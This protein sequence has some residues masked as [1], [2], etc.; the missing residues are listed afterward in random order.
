MKL[1]S[2]V[3]ISI[4]GIA[5]SE[6]KPPSVNG[7]ASGQVALPDDPVFRTDYTPD[8]LGEELLP[9]SP[10]KGGAESGPR[11]Q[12][13][14]WDRINGQSQGV[15]RG[16]KGG[17]AAM[18]KAQE[19]MRKLIN[20]RTSAVMLPPCTS[21]F[22]QILTSSIGQELLAKLQ[23]I[24]QSRESLPVSASRLASVED[25]ANMDDR[26]QET[27]KISP[28]ELE[29]RRRL[30]ALRR[31]YKPLVEALKENS[32]RRMAM[33]TS[34]YMDLF[35]KAYI[36]EILRYYRLPPDERVL[37][38]E[39]ER[40]ENLTYEFRFWQERRE[41]APPNI[42]PPSPPDSMSDDASAHDETGPAE[43]LMAKDLAQFEGQAKGQ[44]PEVDGTVIRHHRGRHGHGQNKEE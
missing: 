43:P 19:E 5:S 35:D 4:L 20:D 29:R 3:L 7:T 6:T 25:S 22:T 42:P 40:W 15:S 13:A 31:K 12:Q 33:G 32:I 41:T 38:E 24:I 27:A 36:A 2:L 10:N 34:V 26:S 30:A 17:S 14:I 21:D 23:A 44:D 28:Q 1:S 11:I 39:I 8:A 16:S 9:G 37:P 18:A